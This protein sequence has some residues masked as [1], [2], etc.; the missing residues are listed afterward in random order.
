MTR[1]TDWHISSYSG[2][3][4]NCVEVKVAD[5]N[6]PGVVRARDSKDA[7]IPEV[8]VPTA[9]WGAFVDYVS[10]PEV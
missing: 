9:A 10:H 3:N 1:Q 2:S 4:D 6:L 5:P 8:R 7:S